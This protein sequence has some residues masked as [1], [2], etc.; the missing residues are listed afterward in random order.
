MY[1]TPDYEIVARI[2]YLSPNTKKSF[3]KKMINQSEHVQQSMR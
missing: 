3:R 2:L 1:A